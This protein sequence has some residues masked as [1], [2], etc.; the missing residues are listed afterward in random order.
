M[1]TDATVTIDHNDL[2]REQWSFCMMPD[3]IVLQSWYY[4]T[5]ETKRHKFKSSKYD[6]T[7]WQRLDR[8]GNRCEMPVPPQSVIDAVI[9]DFRQS[10]K[11]AE[12]ETR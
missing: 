4:L 8:R 7:E 3:G 9:N 6:G 12:K 5:R 1:K 2:C 11:M 10:I